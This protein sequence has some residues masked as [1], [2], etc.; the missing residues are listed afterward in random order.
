MFARLSAFVIWALVAATVVF[1]G[2]RLL[3]RAPAAPEQTVVVGDANVARGDL[4]R[5][6]GSA[7]VASA[8]AAPAAD[9]NSRFKLLGIMAAKEEPGAVATHGVALIAVDGKIPK[10]YLVGASV[11]GDLTLQSVSLRTVSIGAGPGPASI[12]LELPP[13]AV[14]AVGKLPAGGA[15]TSQVPVAPPRPATPVTAAPPPGQP[16]AQPSA[17]GAQVP[18]YENGAV[19]LP[20]QP[21][22]APQPSG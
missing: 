17:S 7:V 11:D 5:L 13:P 20:P 12:T 1:W 15:P 4:S 16:Q 19:V 14:A 10:A 2:L 3:V 9:A 6:L 8:G 18:R 22:R 21:A